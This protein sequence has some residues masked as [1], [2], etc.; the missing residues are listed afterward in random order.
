MLEKKSK[1]KKNAFQYNHERASYIAA[2]P[3][4]TVYEHLETTIG[5]LSDA[6]VEI[7]N[8]QYGDNEITREQRDKGLIVF[9]KTF[10]NTWYIRK[11]ERWL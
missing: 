2:Q 11:F 5:G 10:I 4:K 7:R 9:I 3:V 6:E 8:H 1:N